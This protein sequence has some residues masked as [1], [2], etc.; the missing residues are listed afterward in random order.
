MAHR[1]AGKSKRQLAFSKVFPADS[2]A[3]IAN[4]GSR[5]AYPWQRY[6][7]TRGPSD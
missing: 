4:L 3:A 6:R 2:V 5:P 7:L 1:L